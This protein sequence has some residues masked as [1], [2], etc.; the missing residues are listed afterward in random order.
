[1]MNIELEQMRYALAVT[2]QIIFSYAFKTNRNYN[3]VFANC[4]LFV[5]FGLKSVIF[6][7]LYILMNLTILLLL[8]EVER[9]KAAVLVLNLII[10][11]VFNRFLEDGVTIAGPLMILSIKFYYVNSEINWT[12]DTFG[13]ICEYLFSVPCVL[14]GPAFSLN[15]YKSFK[16][17]EQG[18][19]KKQI[20]KENEVFNRIQT[21]NETTNSGY[22]HRL[23]NMVKN[24]CQ[25]HLN[26]FVNTCLAIQCL[27]YMA[28]YL[29]LP[30]IAP[31]SGI[32]NQRIFFKIPYLIVSLYGFKAK[33]YFAWT[34]SELCCNLHGFPNVRNVNV[35]NVE[36]SQDFKGYTDNW[37]IYV[38][39]WLKEAIFVPAKTFGKFR[40][41]MITFLYSS[42]WH[43]TNLSFFLLFLSIGL[44]IKPLRRAKTFI[45][46]HT[47]ETMARVLNIVTF[48]L[49][50]FYYSMPF[51]L[52]N[53]KKTIAVWKALFFYGH[54][55]LGPFFVMSRSIK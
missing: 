41:S 48:N 43:G 31:V 5:A 20:S 42:L 34:V 51:V 45:C 9:K 4:I 22:R 33:Y 46:A 38:H 32:V 49:I 8:I 37:N 7:N 36:T 28:A 39:K 21:A 15:D 53:M 2:L 12:K 54:I 29:V 30:I 14:A 19:L 26:L 16:R 11:Q 25:S 17:N 35:W 1:M 52:M 23:V 55:V 44:I 50:F 18:I 3:S 40:A 27:I 6:F 47:P 13:Q 10:L 24:H